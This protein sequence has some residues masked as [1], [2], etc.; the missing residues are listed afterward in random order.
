MG[1]QC[2]GKKSSNSAELPTAV[3]ILVHL[4]QVNR[5]LYSACTK[6]RRKAELAQRNNT[7]VRDR[8]SCYTSSRDACSVIL[9]LLTEIELTYS[10]E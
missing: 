2:G 7:Y 10:D 5:A 8:W 3:A 4:I 1:T 9:K 6:L